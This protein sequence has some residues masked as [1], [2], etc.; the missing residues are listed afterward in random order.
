MKNFCGILAHDYGCNCI[1]DPNEI[2]ITIKNR[3]HREYYLDKPNRQKRRL[4]K[5]K[6]KTLK[7]NRR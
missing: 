2:V 7:K 6:L 3:Y 1:G 4:E 5:K